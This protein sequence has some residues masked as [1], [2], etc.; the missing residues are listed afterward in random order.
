MTEWTRGNERETEAIKMIWA[1]PCVWGLMI[2][3]FLMAVWR[4][5][6]R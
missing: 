2:V 5:P 1:A 3:R 4:H 6:L